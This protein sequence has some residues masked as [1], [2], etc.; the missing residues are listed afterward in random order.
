MLARRSLPITFLRRFLGCADFPRRLIF[1][2]DFGWMVGP[3]AIR[4]GWRAGDLAVCRTG[5]VRGPDSTYPAGRLSPQ[6]IGSL[7]RPK[8]RHRARLVE[9]P[10]IVREPDEIP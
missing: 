9:V 8:A 5:T 1:N 2:R 10:I 6:R 4:D 7:Q 3:I